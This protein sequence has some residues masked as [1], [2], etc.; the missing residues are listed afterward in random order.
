MTDESTPLFRKPWGIP[1]YFVIL[2]G[3]AL[4]DAFTPNVQLLPFIGRYLEAGATFIQSL[5]QA[6][7][8]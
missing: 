2:L 4:L 7:V 8:N 1:E 5:F 6:G 3:V